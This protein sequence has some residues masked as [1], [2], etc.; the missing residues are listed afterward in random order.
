MSKR[1]KKDLKKGIKILLVGSS[2]RMGQ[3]ILSLM[4][5]AKDFKCSY[6]ISSRNEDWSKIDPKHVDLV[7]DFSSPQAFSAALRWSVKNVKP[8]LSGTTGLTPAQFTQIKAA[9]KEIPILWASNMSLGIAVL[10]SFMASMSPLKKWK[11][12]IEETHHRHKKDKPSGTALTLQADLAL[13]VG[14]RLPPIVSIRG[15]GVP[16]IHK[17]TAMSPEEVITIEHTALNRRV[18]ARG[19]LI[20]ARWLFDK[21]RAGLYDLGNIKGARA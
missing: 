12:Q 5:E 10:R 6:Q 17:I 2:G 21:K 15:G 7:I 1:L 18:F 14:K 16:G 3:E 4:G 13:A 8:F 20:A 11:F 9:A 19:A